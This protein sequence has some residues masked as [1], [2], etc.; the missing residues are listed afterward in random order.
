[1]ARVSAAATALW[2]S[3]IACLFTWGGKISVKIV[4]IQK[5][6]PKITWLTASSA[7][8]LN[9]AIF[10]SVCLLISLINVVSCRLGTTLPLCPS[11]PLCCS[12]E[13]A[14]FVLSTMPEMQD[15]IV[16]M[17]FHSSSPLLLAE[18]FPVAPFNGFVRPRLDSEVTD[19]IASRSS[20]W[21]CCNN[22]RGGG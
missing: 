17:F 6:P 21:L 2:I 19:R 15:S 9:S 16:W 10:S 20:L 5:F 1:M 7:F 22:R 14:L 18:L 8:R 12:I 13:M 3:S 11:F 4:F